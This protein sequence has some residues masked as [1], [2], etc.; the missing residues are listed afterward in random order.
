MAGPN[1]GGTKSKMTPKGTS[2][3]KCDSTMCRSSYQDAHY[4]AGRR[5]FNNARGERRCTVCGFKKN[6]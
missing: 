2:V 5:V 4:G 6:Y 1:V 3:M